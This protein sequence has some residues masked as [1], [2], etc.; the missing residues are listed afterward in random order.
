MIDLTF[1]NI[2]TSAAVTLRYVR[3][4]EWSS[5]ASDNVFLVQAKRVGHRRREIKVNGFINKTMFNDAVAAQQQLETDLRN[6][7]VGTLSYTGATPFTDVRFLSLDFQEY[8][9][10]PVATFT[11]TFATEEENIHAHTSNKIGNLTLT[12]ANGYEEPSVRDA[13]TVQGPDE[14]LRDD[15]SRTF[16]I[17]GTFV[18]STLDEIQV[19]QAAIVAE[20]EN[21]NT[22]IV[23]FSSASGNP[24]AYTVRPR[25][26][27]FSAPRVRDGNVA[28]SYTFECNT[29]D[30][31]DQEPYTLGEVPQ[32]FAGILLSVVRSVNHKVTRDRTGGGAIYI[33]NDESVA[34][35]GKHYFTGWTQ[36]KALRD[37]FDPIP[38]NTY[39]LTSTTGNVLELIDFSMGQMD[40]DGN[41]TNGDKRYS[42]QVNLTFEWARALE[43]RVYEY[44]QA[45]FGVQFFTVDNVAFNVSIDDRG[46]QNSRSVSV[47][48]AVAGLANLNNLKSKVGTKV[49]YDVTYNNLYITSVTVS[50]TRTALIGT[51][52][53]Q[54]YSVTVTATQLGNA[55]QAFNY[56]S[57]IFDFNRATGGSVTD[58]LTIDNITSRSKSISNT[59]KQFK[60]EVAQITL[61]VTGEVF[62]VDNPATNRPNNPDK[63]LTIFNKIDSLLSSEVSTDE[64]AT[65]TGNVILP[66]NTNIHFFLNS[67][68]LGSWEPFMLSNVRLW[69]QTVNLSA[70]A[71]FEL[72]AGGGTTTEPDVVET[73][74][75]SITLEAPKYQQIQTLGFGTVFKIVGTTP[76]S[77]TVTY[78]VSWRTRLLY[79]QANQGNLN[80][81]NDDINPGSNGWRGQGK[82]VK[83]KDQKENRGLTNRH[84]VE[85]LATEKLG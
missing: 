12:T 84:I 34:V 14:Q 5:K 65:H 31:Y 25:K 75:D 38:A 15:K 62:E 8:R 58:Q 40:R 42:A 81:G 4:V 56:I 32:S 55:A 47:T 43:G 59:F 23:T 21:K 13:I 39:F 52:Q 79:Q 44:N 76:E 82:N 77:L 6:I 18:A 57:G 51:L 68:S 16:V 24:A 72:T 17:E 41:Y 9:G 54:I 10:N 64:A 1:T 28:R 3:S 36:Y 33:V 46:N 22:L 48:G 60:F 85:Y 53:T 70:T 35:S 45:H 73:R 69:K 19:L 71:I 26:L 80:F 83:T 30:D 74:S 63:V 66:G 78:T 11:I 67:F 20:V 50:G 7:G 49:D 29:H 37:L 27:E 2:S 61:S